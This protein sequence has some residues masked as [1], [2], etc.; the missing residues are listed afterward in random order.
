MP[1][2]EVRVLT[3]GRDWRGVIVKYIVVINFGDV[4]YYEY[5]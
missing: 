4:E 1:K 2:S 5:T 3:S